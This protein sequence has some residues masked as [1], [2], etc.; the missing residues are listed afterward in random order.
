MS[1]GSAT[2]TIKF[3][4]KAGT[5]TATILCPDGDLYQEWVGSESEVSKIYPNFVNTTPLL[6]FVC[7][8]S[9]SA[10]G[11]VTPDAVLYYFNGQKI[12]FNGDTSS[13]TFAGLFKKISPSANQLYYGLKIVKNIVEASGFA[14][15][16]I[17]M[18]GTVSYGTQVDQIQATYTIPIQKSTG[19]SYRVTIKSGDNN[20]FVI[21]DK[22]GSCVLK[23]VASQSGEEITKDL[24][25][26]WEKMGKSGWAI[27]ENKTAQTITVAAADIDTYGEYRVTVNL[28]G[29]EIGKDI[30]G[31]MDSS[32][33]FDIDP[34]PVPEDE[35]IDED[36]SGNGQVVYTPVV[37]KRGTGTKAL[38][39]QFYFVI[40]DAAG[41]I[42]NTDSNTAKSSCTVKREHCVQAG[43]DVSITMT[44]KD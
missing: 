3:V 18:V 5:Y 38:D 42:L 6:N 31:V 26:Q 33:P 19:T 8:S 21:R 2:R 1:S 7:T 43:G 4:S 35:T 10:E 9:R 34:H 15:A 24:T 16:T 30:Q 40:K 32:D 27:L 13:G 36:A 22:S 14:P 29:V 20:N 23:A 25:Y 17:K 39:T 41:V 12:E 37:V 11:I 44:A 28:A